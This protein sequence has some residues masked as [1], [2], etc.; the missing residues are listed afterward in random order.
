M[1][2]IADMEAIDHSAEPT[3]CPS[4]ML[5]I[6]YALQSLA[7]APSPFDT[8]AARR[9]S[10]ISLCALL[11]ALPTGGE[12]LLK[13]V[14]PGIATFLTRDFPALIT[15]EEEGVLPRLRPRLLLGDDFDDLINTMSEEHRE[16]R[17]LAAG[18]ARRCDAFA[19]GMEDDWPDLC[20]ALIQFAERQRRHL[21]W[22]DAT[23][24]PIARERLSGQDLTSWRTDMDRRYQN[25][26]FSRRGFDS[27]ASCHNQTETSDG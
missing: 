17:Q 27:N 24:I 25:L 23:I 10:L 20:A 11:R 2:Y 5:Q 7:A 13:A 12:T 3:D 16:D 19:K 1:S 9:I 18:L 6:D 26:L 8:L 4:G 14:T 15:E 22:E 21:A